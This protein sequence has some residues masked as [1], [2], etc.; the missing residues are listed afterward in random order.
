MNT[1]EPDT[2]RAARTGAWTASTAENEW[3]AFPGG[4]LEGRQL[5]VR[6]WSCRHRA[7]PH[8]RTLCFQ[9]FREALVSERRL[10]AAA[11]LE[12]ASEA[13]FQHT[14]PFEPVDT[15]RLERLRAERSHERLV[16][17]TDRFITR[18]HR[19]QIAARHALQMF[20]AASVNEAGKKP[21]ADV[22]TRA[23]ELQLPEAWLPFVVSR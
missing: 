21:M 1:S 19:A 22:A 16:N 23:A 3:V 8:P 17:G 13:R 4:E 12:T 2:R 18:R 14:L 15:R 10:M 9:C 5:E 11:Q 7:T 20:I 6:G